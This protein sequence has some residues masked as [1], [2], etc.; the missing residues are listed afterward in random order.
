MCRLNY[1]LPNEVRRTVIISV[2]RR[3][4]KT[5]N[6]MLTSYYYRRDEKYFTKRYNAEQRRHTAR[7][8]FRSDF[9]SIGPNLCN[10]FNATNRTRQFTSR[11]AHKLNK[12]F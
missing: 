4:R 12:C 1:C 8:S 5:Y 11:N 7:V 3:T 6:N 2:Q 10:P 9:L